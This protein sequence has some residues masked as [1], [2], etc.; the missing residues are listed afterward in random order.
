MEKHEW[1]CEG[2]GETVLFRQPEKPQDDW[3]SEQNENMS[4]PE[5]DEEM[6][7]DVVGGVDE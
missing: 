3:R 5:C 7:F 4:C 1:I 6:Y 2:C